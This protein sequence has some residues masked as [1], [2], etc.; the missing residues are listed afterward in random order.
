MRANLKKLRKR[1]IFADEFKQSLVKEFDTGQFSVN[2]LGR[3]HGIA[4]SAIYR[5][6]YKFSTFNQKGYRIIEMKDSSKKK[7][8]DLEQKIK[9]LE[10]IV[11][12][13]QIMIDYLEKMMEIAKDEL[14]IDIKKNF[15]TSQSTGSG[16][17]KK[18]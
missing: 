4:N 6:I 8:K 11:G 9:N 14:D 1:R 13:K 5:W 3:L 7:L 15:N 18:K 17:T 12:Q 10:Q 16:K 2:E